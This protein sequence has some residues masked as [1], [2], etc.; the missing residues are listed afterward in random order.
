MTPAV[1]PIVKAGLDFF[2]Y[3]L[4]LLRQL[5]HVLVL[6]GVPRCSFLTALVEKANVFGSGPFSFVEHSGS[7]RVAQLR[8][9][10]VCLLGRL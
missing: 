1:R 9:E 10:N 5:S 7:L 8:T 4:C 6:E 2:L 3:I